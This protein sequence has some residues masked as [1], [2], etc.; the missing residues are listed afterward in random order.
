[1]KINPWRV[2]A[3]L[4]LALSLGGMVASLTYFNTFI[5]WAQ[6][7]VLSYI[8]VRLEWVISGLV[9]ATK[10]YTSDTDGPQP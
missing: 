1:M 4:L 2:A 8:L 9:N 5:E 3:I 10:S 6:L 7:S